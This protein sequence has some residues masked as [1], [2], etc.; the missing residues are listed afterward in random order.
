MLAKL[1]FYIKR[2]FCKR[3]KLSHIKDT[4][5]CKSCIK[6]AERF[7]AINFYEGELDYL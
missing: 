2:F 7:P 5:N 3:I 6:Y 1:R 4:L